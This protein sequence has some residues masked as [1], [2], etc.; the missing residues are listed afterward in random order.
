MKH[1][2]R[3][4]DQL[5]VFSSLYFK[6][7]RNDAEVAGNSF[8]FSQLYNLWEEWREKEKENRSKKLPAPLGRGQ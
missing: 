2:R 3:N 6:C 8:N 4:S 7:S 1:L 5:S